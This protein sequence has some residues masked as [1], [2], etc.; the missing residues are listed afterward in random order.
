MPKV[1]FGKRAPK[2]RVSNEPKPKGRSAKK[3]KP[4]LST[5]VRSNLAA[6]IRKRLQLNQGVFARLLPVSVRSLATVE[7]GAEPSEVVARRLCE[8]R[9]LTDALTEVIRQESLGK[10]LQTPNEAFDGL[11]PLEVIERGESHR[12]WSMIYFLR[13][14][15]P[16]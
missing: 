13:S 10:W 5:S 12:I 15:T 6:D 11:K 2:H 16:S 14:G 4:N 1:D 7:S 3:E 8:L 9:R